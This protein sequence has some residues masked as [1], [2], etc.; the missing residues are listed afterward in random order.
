MNYPGAIIGLIFYAAL[1]IYAILNFRKKNIIAFGILFFLISLAPVS[2]IFFLGG[3][4]MAERFLYIPSLGFCLI[5]AYFLIR[6][7]ET[8]TIKSKPNRLVKFFSFNSTLFLFLFGITILYSLKIFSRNKNWKDTLTIFS[9]D[10]QVS[11]N[12]ATAN[13]LLGNSL[14]LRGALSNIR[15]DKLDTFD[16]AKKYL[17]R[18]LEIAPGFYDA[19][20][21]LGYVFLVENKADSAYLYL[22]EGVKFGPND[23][24]LNNYFGSALLMLGKFDD[25][26]KVFSHI[27]S[28]SP[29]HEEAYFNLAS[30]YLGKGDADNSL[31]SYSKVIEIDPNNAK[32]YYLAAGIL[33]TK[34]DTLKAKEFIS[35]AKSLGYKPK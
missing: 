31:L 16:L 18:A 17:K 1:V 14:V 9:H 27:I 21:N 7:T 4:S 32:A 19:S 20:S 30:A 12:S 2:N 5:L 25:A 23:V 22:K 24:Q 6:F 11:R 26:I 15:E 3:S 10:I 28:L 29:K 35:K 33:N 34:G 13:E 8:R